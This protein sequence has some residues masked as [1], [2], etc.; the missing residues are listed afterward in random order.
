MHNK[1]KLLPHPNVFMPS[2][3]SLL[4]ASL[5]EKFDIV[6][7]NVLDVGCGSGLFSII[8]G[9]MGA[10]TVVAT[11][12]NQKALELTKT[13]WQLNGLKSNLIT[14]NT[15]ALE[16]IR[17]VKRWNLFFD[18]IIS[19]PPML[20]PLFCKPSN[21]NREKPSDWNETSENGRHVVNSLIKNS[22]MLLKEGGILLFAHSSRLG[23]SNTKILLDHN[24]SS[25]EQ[26][27]EK[28]FALEDRFRPFINFWLRN[29]NQIF[30]KNGIF[31]EKLKII[32][33]N[34]E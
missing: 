1:I 9:K 20:P 25:W 19:N 27:I 18:I 7:K 28:E 33:A 21:L 14:I 30:C 29:E 5:L 22:N 16:N 34:K 32:K 6:G 8:T 4:L 26:I 15:D 12:I 10:H 11:D 23:F 2:K 13:N 24:F 17:K 3:R 31:F